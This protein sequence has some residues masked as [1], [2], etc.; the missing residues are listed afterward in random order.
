MNARGEKGFTLVEILV[1]ISIGSI[2]LTTIYGVFSSVSGAR[3][4]LEAVGEEYHQARVLYDRMAGEIR[5]GYFSTSSKQTRLLAG[6]NN[7]GY[8]F[9]EFSTTLSTPLFGGRPGGISLVRYEQLEMEQEIRL[10]RSEWPLLIDKSELRPQLLITGLKTFSLRYYD[11]S[12]WQDEWD[13]QQTG[14][15]PKMIE[16]TIEVELDEQVHSFL[17]TI[18]LAGS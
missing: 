4:R 7:Q 16:L 3:D 2:L 9:L 11:G 6:S 8:P 10:Y 17:S 14:M 12:D 1:A 15:L 5:S 13:S 18:E